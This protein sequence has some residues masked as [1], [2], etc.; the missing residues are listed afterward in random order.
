MI[1]WSQY[2]TQ[3]WANDVR[4]RSMNFW[5]QLK[6][7][8]DYQGSI[9]V[10]PNDFTPGCAAMQLHELVLG[11]NGGI[12]FSWPIDRAQWFKCVQWSNRL[13]QRYPLHCIAQMTEQLSST[14]TLQVENQSQI[15]QIA[16][17]A[18]Q[19]STIKFIAT[20]PG[21]SFCKSVRAV[22]PAE[23]HAPCVTRWKLTRSS[24][25]YH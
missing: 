24:G 2:Y 9:R 16:L 7:I 23:R 20:N 10:P 15:V 17:Y 3:P 21:S 11:N 8:F 19:N 13:L 6:L 18:F 25:W 12:A 14:C 4:L 1:F 22:C 5:Y